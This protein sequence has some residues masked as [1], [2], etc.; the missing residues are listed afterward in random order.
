MSVNQKIQLGVESTAGTAVAATKIMSPWTLDMGI[1]PEVKEFRGTGR[2][3]AYNVEENKE[4][5]ESKLSGWMD[6]NS[7]VYLLSSVMGKVTP[8]LHAPSSTAYDWI[9]DASLTGPAS[10]Q[11]YTIEQGDSVRAQKIAYALIND[12]NYK[13]S[14]DEATF[15]AQMMAQAITDAITLTSLSTSAELTVSS[16]LGKYINVYYDTASGSLGTT[17]FAKPLEMNF[18]FG[19]VFAPFWTLN[20][21]NTSFASHLDMAPKTTIKMLT[22]ADAA[23]M[24][25]LADLQGDATTIKYLRV[26]A[27]G[28]TID[29]TN[30]IK[31]T[32]W[33]DLA[34]RVSNV[35]PFADKNGVYAIEWEWTVVE[36]PTWGHS[37]KFTVTNLLSTL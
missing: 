13:I 9:F 28:P 11:T 25:L 27:I 33:H 5:S 3:Y 30:S 8:A 10:P 23:G 32:I 22:E 35:Q 19:G 17:Q 29:A 7:L 31:A 4:W 36:D 20:R 15:G 6:F 16:V 24:A 18:S 37:H 21:T 26:E 1:K 12:F 14:R 34:V 2:K